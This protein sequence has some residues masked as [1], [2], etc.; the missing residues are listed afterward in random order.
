V[1]AHKPL[2]RRPVRVCGGNGRYQAD[3][4]RVLEQEARGRV[5][6]E[7]AGMVCVVCW[8]GLSNV[9]ISLFALLVSFPVSQPRLA[10]PR[11]ASVR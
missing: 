3:H 6:Q 1:V 4:H 5:C 10:L 8:L 2:L 9:S 11:L 7:Q